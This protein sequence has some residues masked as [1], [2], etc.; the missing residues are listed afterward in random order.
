MYI[1]KNETEDA[2]AFRDDAGKHFLQPGE[3]YVL[4]GDQHAEAARLAGLA[5]RWATK[6]PARQPVLADE[7]TPVSR[8]RSRRR[9]ASVTVREE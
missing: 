6:A 7:A 8:P 5:V 2:R 9:K 1:V 3:R 4:V